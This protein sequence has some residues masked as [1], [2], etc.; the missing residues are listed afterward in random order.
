MRF[1]AE[2]C[3]K[4][5]TKL[6]WK[7]WILP[8]LFGERINRIF[9][10]AL[11]H[12]TRDR[13]GNCLERSDV[14]QL[15]TKPIMFRPGWNLL[16]RLP[17][18]RGRVIKSPRPI[19]LGFFFGVESWADAHGRYRWHQQLTCFQFVYLSSPAVFPLKIV[20]I[21][22]THILLNYLYKTHFLICKL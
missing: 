3:P 5:H 8:V 2:K 15:L 20:H 19:F 6:G 21:D 14:I 1:K 4:E 7:F 17:V 9:L 12:V 18:V 11:E 13:D 22:Q 16:L 10:L